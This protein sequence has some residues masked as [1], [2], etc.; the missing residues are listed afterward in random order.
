MRYFA[1][2]SEVPDVTVIPDARALK[3]KF[4]RLRMN[5]AILRKY[6][7]PSALGLHTSQMR[8]CPRS[9]RAWSGAVRC[10]PESISCRFWPELYWFKEYVVFRISPH[11]RAPTLFLISYTRASAMALRQHP[12]SENR[13]K[14]RNLLTSSLRCACSLA[15]IRV[16]QF[17]FP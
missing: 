1:K 17:A 13:A 11:D 7:S 12:S 4:I 14:Y 15:R 6:H 2:V 8:V 3:G 9:L 16:T 5:G 10:L